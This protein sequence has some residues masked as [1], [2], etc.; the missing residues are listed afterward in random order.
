MIVLTLVSNPLS[1]MGSFANERKKCKVLF[2]TSVFS[3]LEGRK[4]LVG[5]SG[6]ISIKY[7]PLYHK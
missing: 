6:E 2:F 5:L 3:E 4:F 1:K 7:F